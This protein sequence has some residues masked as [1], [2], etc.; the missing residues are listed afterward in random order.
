MK[1]K[2]KEKMRGTYFIADL[3]AYRVYVWGDYLYSI[4][5]SGHTE[6]IHEYKMIVERGE[7]KRPSGQYK[8]LVQIEKYKEQ[9]G[10]K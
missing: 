1:K 2:K 5:L 8:L 9:G 6:R 4:E 10:D 3:R 7:E